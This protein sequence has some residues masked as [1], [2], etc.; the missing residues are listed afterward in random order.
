MSRVLQTKIETKT[1]KQE[2]EQEAQRVVPPLK[3][4]RQ[5]SWLIRSTMHILGLADTGM[6]RD[7]SARTMFAS[8]CTLSLPAGN[9]SIKSVF[10]LPEF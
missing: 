7:T 4:K 3:Q 9:S 8:F 5:R 6:V 10:L 2:E 1:Y